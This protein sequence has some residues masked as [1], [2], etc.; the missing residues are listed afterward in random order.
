M[1]NSGSALKDGYWPRA[2]ELAVVKVER[3]PVEQAEGRGRGPEPP[4]PD[5][6]SN[7]RNG[8][9]RPYDRVRSAVKPRNVRKGGGGDGVRIREPKEVHET[10]SH[11]LNSRGD[12]RS[13]TLVCQAWTPRGKRPRQGPVGNAD[14]AQLESGYPK[15]S[16]Q[17]TEI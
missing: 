4:G 3:S 5:P 7:G 9:K 1:A 12:P 16:W 2:P 11:P 8:R 15:I 14:A 13:R 10:G 17:C 6:A